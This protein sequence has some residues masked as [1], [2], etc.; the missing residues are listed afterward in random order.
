[1]KITGNEDSTSELKP[2]R[3]SVYMVEEDALVGRLICIT[4]LQFLLSIIDIA[5]VC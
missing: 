4:L 3:E 2:L 1:M 5:H